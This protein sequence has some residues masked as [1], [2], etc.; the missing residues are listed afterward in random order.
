MTQINRTRGPVQSTKKGSEPNQNT[1]TIRPSRN[2][3]TSD[4]ASI[5][6]NPRTIQEPRRARKRGKI[7]INSNVQFSNLRPATLIPNKRIRSRATF[8]IMINRDS[9]D[10]NHETMQISHDRI[11]VTTSLKQ[12]SSSIDQYFRLMTSTKIS[13]NISLNITLLIS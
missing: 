11:P 3:R 12:P 2:I 1:N 9:S 8:T 10:C 6:L 4:V 5:N 7:N 13:S